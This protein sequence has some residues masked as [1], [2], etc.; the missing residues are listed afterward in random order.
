M[1]NSSGQAMQNPQ[2]LNNKIEEKRDFNSQALSFISAGVA[3][4]A[5][6]LIDDL[7]MMDIMNNEGRLSIKYLLSFPNPLVLQTAF[8]T[9]RQNGI[10]KYNKNY[11]YL[12]DFG[13]NLLKHRAS[14]GY[15]YNGYRNLL[16]NQVNIAKDEPS[17]NFDLI[18]SFSIAK[19][20]TYFGDNLIN[21]MILDIVQNCPYRGDICDLGCGAAT[22]L[23]Y[24]CRNTGLKGCGFDISKASLKKARAN[25]EKTDKIS[26]CQKDITKIDKVYSGIEILLQAFVMHDL[27]DDSFQQTLSS[28]RSNFP[29]TK[30]FIYIDAVASDDVNSS[31]LPGFEYIHSLLNIKLR[32]KKKTLKMFSSSGF[33]VHKELSIPNHPNCYIWI[34]TPSICN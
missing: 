19:A 10:V 11:F 1:L 26:L 27:S 16:S 29:N 34:L 17:Q 6:S 7:G 4:Y 24:L 31:Q 23:V 2:G 9:L 3:C 12:T 33:N 14:I 8:L 5:F 18:D 15:I 28:F 21:E 25:I 13:K 32:N 30:L 20:S 22:R